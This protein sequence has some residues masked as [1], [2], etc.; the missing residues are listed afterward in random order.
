MIKNLIRKLKNNIHLHKFSKPIIS[1]YVSFNTRDIVYECK[2]GK[3]QIFRI[4]R[5]FSDPFPIPT[6][7]DLS[8]KELDSY[9][10]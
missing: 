2:C 5:N 4:Y 1:S 10:K 9:L 6:T 8:K 3:R 7:S